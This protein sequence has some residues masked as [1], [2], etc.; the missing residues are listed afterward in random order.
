MGIYL[1]HQR[2]TQKE[3]E[4]ALDVEMDFRFSN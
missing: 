2:V 3:S 1:L 4:N